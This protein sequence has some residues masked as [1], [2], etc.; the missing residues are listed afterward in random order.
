MQETKLAMFISRGCMCVAPFLCG[1]GVENPGN[2]WS[3]RAGALPTVLAV[4]D[5]S[6]E[7]QREVQQCL[8]P[9]GG[10]GPQWAPP[11]GGE[12]V[13][14][15]RSRLDIRA[16]VS[17][18]VRSPPPPPPRASFLPWWGLSLLRK[19]V[20]QFRWGTELGGRDKGGRGRRVRPV[21]RF[22]STAGAPAGDGLVG[23]PMGA[24]EDLL[25]QPE[26]PR[27]GQPRALLRG[28]VAERGL[29]PHR[30]AAPHGLVLV[31]MG[32]ASALVSVPSPRAKKRT[33]PWGFWRPKNAPPPSRGKARSTKKENTRA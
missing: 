14:G 3:S 16:V 33:L 8:G 1:K 26:E 4:V 22:P 6:A 17:C 25:R 9:R 27:R 13:R 20:F 23:V 19:A 11:G 2:G 10:P 29:T 31:L 32:F 18:W 21:L 24:D 15:R 12:I 7:D 5:T 28:P 30:T